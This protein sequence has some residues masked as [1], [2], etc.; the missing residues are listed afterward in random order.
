MRVVEETLGPEHLRR[1]VRFMQEGTN[2]L[3]S[4]AAPPLLRATSSF[5]S[6]RR[7]PLALYAMREYIG[8]ERIDDA[9]RHL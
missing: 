6:S 3:R 9:L 5:A 7:A 8:K 2:S 1:Y 4:R